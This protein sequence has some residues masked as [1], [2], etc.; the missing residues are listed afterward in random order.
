MKTKLKSRHPIDIPTDWKRS[1][2]PAGSVLIVATLVV[3]GGSLLALALGLY[4]ALTV[5]GRRGLAIAIGLGLSSALVGLGLM[6]ALV[7]SR[8]KP[9]QDERTLELH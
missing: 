3:V 1:I 2:G 8:S 9:Y 4:D 5:P 6:T 7:A